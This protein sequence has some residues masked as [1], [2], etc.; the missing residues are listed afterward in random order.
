MS[1]EADGYRQD[2]VMYCPKCEQKS[3]FV[4]QSRTRALVHCT[5]PRCAYFYPVETEPVS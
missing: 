5:D 4:R 2:T 3:V 1:R